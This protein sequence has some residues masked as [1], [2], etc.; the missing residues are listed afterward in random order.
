M[1][2]TLATNHQKPLTNRLWNNTRT[3]YQKINIFLKEIFFCEASFEIFGNILF[4]AMKSSKLNDYSTKTQLT[5]Y[6]TTIR[7]QHTI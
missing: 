5:C 3:N 4:V 7:T 2:A 6:S 1:V